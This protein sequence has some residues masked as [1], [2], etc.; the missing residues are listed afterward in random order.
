MESRNKMQVECNI[1]MA[2]FL[3]HCILIHKAMIELF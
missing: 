3:S 1:W 2:M